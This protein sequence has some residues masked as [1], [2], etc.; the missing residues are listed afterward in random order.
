MTTDVCALP[1]WLAGILAKRPETGLLIHAMLIAG[2]QRGHVTAEDVHHI[3][4]SHPN[5]RGAAMKMLRHAGFTKGA[6]IT[7]AT[8]AS[9][10]HY[11]H[12]WVLTDRLLAQSILRA[13]SGHVLPRQPATGQL[14][15]AV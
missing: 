6:E 4:V 2:L 12:K 1:S 13:M 11:L 14:E 7:G 9:K 5:C 3:P 15:L 8:A 10:G